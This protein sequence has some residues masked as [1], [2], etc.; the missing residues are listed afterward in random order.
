M[1]ERRASSLDQHWAVPKQKTHSDSLD[2]QPESDSIQLGETAG[3]VDEGDVP[4]AAADRLT[5]LSCHDSGIDIRETEVLAPTRKVK[6]D[7]EVLLAGKDECVLL[8]DLPMPRTY[9]E[10]VE[11]KDDEGKEEKPAEGK[12]NKVCRFMMCRDLINSWF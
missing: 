7:A 1:Q 6:S 5:K 12:Q 9:E 3:G 8:V 11:K 10:K 4:P 2:S